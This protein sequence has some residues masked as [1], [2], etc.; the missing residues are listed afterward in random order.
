MSIRTCCFWINLPRRDFHIHHYPVLYNLYLAYG[1]GGKL[2]PDYLKWMLHDQLSEDEAYGIFSK[3]G[4]INTTEQASWYIWAVQQAFFQAF[5][6]YIPQK[7][8]YH[9][10]GESYGGHYVPGVA[11]RIVQ[12]NQAIAAGNLSGIV[13]PLQ[14]IGVGNGWIDS[15]IQIPYGAMMWLNNSYGM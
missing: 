3:Q 11:S 8:G 7:T 6:E 14:T 15:L 13:I 5:P 10:F 4:N 2:D 12:Q 1:T 9:I